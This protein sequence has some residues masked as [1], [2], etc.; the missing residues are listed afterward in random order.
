MTPR[1]STTIGATLDAT[2]S[3]VYVPDTAL[4]AVERLRTLGEVHVWWW[5]LGDRTDPADHA[6][7]DAVERG[8]ARRFHAEADAAAFTATRAG[9]R[10]AIA[11]LLGITPGEVG[12][13]RRICPGCGDPEHGPPSVVRPPVPLAVSLSR[14]AGIGALAVRAGD[15]VGVDVEAL[16][17]VDD[18]LADVVLTPSERAYVMGRPRGPE[19]DAAFHRTWTRKEAVVKAVGLGLLGMELHAL[20]VRPADPGPV[21]VVH[22][23]RSETT[24]WEVRDLAVP[25]PWSASLAR[26]LGSALGEVRLHAPAGAGD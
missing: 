6:V 8:R 3:E 10:R 5:P 4:A 13:G 11:G 26:P 24:R 18:N 17:P 15:W 12:L 2:I 9:A 20:D 22:T 16:R 1:G 23:Y 14:T 25:G 21:E 7:L 19:R